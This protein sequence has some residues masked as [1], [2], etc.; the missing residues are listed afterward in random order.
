MNSEK[1]QQ[2]TRRQFCTAAAAAALG[3]WTLPLVAAEEGSFSF[4]VLGD[5]HFDRPEHHDMAWLESSH[6]GDVSQSKN[7]SR[8]TREVTP[9][10]FA[11]VRETVA[12]AK[13]PAAFVAQ[14]GDFV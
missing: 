6:P 2:Y 7:Y 9:K 10:L 3:I 14:L 11:E 4:V 5:L 8:I 13:P 12:G 1:E